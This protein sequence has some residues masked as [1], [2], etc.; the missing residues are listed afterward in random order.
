M[1]HPGVPRGHPEAHPLPAP[2][3]R[4]RGSSTARRRAATPPP[5]RASAATA[6]GPGPRPQPAAAA[7]PRM[8][9]CLREGSRVR[10]LSVRPQFGRALP[11]CAKRHIAALR[12][13]RRGLL[14]TLGG[15]VRRGGAERRACETSWPQSA[16]R[17]T[18]ERG[19]GTERSCGDGSLLV[20]RLGCADR[21]QKGLA[22]RRAGKAGRGSIRVR[23]RREESA[24]VE[25][26][27]PH[28]ACVLGRR[29]KQEECGE[30]EPSEPRAPPCRGS[31]MGRR[32]TG[33]PASAWTNSGGKG[34]SCGHGW[35]RCFGNPRTAA[36]GSRAGGGQVRRT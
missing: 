15:G 12:R 6:A 13:R 16:R 22:E 27:Q 34:A 36:G 26:S 24:Q 21:S 20:V 8:E 28:K 33:L 35:G 32:P 19:P 18:S 25:T 17:E 31:G 4:Q 29:W 14:R 1:R 7:P 23:G 10:R 5:A 2:Q 9:A 30:V 3:Q 11:G